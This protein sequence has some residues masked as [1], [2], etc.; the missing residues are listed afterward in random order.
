MFGGEKAQ[1]VTKQ[2]A[3]Q[4]V[5][6]CIA[7]LQPSKIRVVSLTTKFAVGAILSVSFSVHY[8]G[9]AGV[10]SRL[11]HSK[12]VS[13]FQVLCII[14]YYG[15]DGIQLFRTACHIISRQLLAIVTIQ[16]HFKDKNPDIRGE[17]A[18]Q[19]DQCCKII[20]PFQACH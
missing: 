3:P 11:G 4:V 18:E 19:L 8:H 16:K 14:M 1:R 9:G 20:S 7:S 10:N 6:A 12:K 5:Q 17:I 2:Y 15:L 13:C